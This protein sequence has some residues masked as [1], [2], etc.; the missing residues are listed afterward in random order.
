M[1]GSATI[2]ASRVNVLRS[3]LNGGPTFPHSLGTVLMVS[4]A[5]EAMHSNQAG[6]EHGET[7][8]QPV[9]TERPGNPALRHCR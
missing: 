8:G 6:N 2:G 7:I 5:H 4:A 1:P 3:M 9:E